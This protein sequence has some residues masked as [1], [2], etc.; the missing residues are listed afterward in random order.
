MKTGQYVIGYRFST[1]DGTV[2][3]EAED[4]GVA[5]SHPIDSDDA[6]RGLLGFLTLKPG[7]TDAEYFAEYT[8]EQHEFAENEAEALQLWGM[9]PESFDN[10]DPP[11][12]EDLSE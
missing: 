3:F 11:A 5:P 1:P 10:G 6:L 12:F 2:L 4:C 9:E 8:P 7:D